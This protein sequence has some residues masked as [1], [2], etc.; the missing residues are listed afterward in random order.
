M[1]Q[2]KEMQQTFE[3]TV[4]FFGD[5][6]KTPVEDFFSQIVDFLLG[7]EKAIKDNIREKRLAERR[8]NLDEKKKANEQQKAKQVNLQV[9]RHQRFY[10]LTLLKQTKVRARAAVRKKVAGGVLDNLAG[11]IRE[12]NVF[13][14]DGKRRRQQSAITYAP[15]FPLSP[16]AL[17]LALRR[18]I[19]TSD[20][21]KE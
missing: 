9:L 1:Q 5:G 10:S 8:K 2:A 14:D 19:L 7:V 16:C 4:V 12:G 17:P 21:R 18:R 15:P 20:N 6:P 3:E 11:T 13:R